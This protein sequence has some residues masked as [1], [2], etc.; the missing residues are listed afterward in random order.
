M[1]ELGHWSQRKYTSALE[2]KHDVTIKLQ[3]CG[4]SVA[5]LECKWKAQ[6]E[7]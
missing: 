7:A 2:Q 4:V 1:I 3:D 5:E 6:V